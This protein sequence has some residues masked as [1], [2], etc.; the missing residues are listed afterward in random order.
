VVE[1][2]SNVEMAFYN[3]GGWESSNLRWVADSGGADSILRFCLE[4]EG[5]G[6]KRCRRIKRRQ[7]ACLGSMGRKCYTTQWHGD[8]SRRK[9]STGEGEWMRRCQLGRRKS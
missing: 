5:D 8:V 1:R 6:M 9:D 4:G 7:R 3:S 2:A